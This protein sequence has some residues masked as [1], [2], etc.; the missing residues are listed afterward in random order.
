MQTSPTTSAFSAQNRPGI[1]RAFIRSITLSPNSNPLYIIPTLVCELYIETG[2]VAAHRAHVARKEFDTWYKFDYRKNSPK[3]VL[4]YGLLAAHLNYDPRSN[5]KHAEDKPINDYR[6]HEPRETWGRVTRIE[7]KEYSVTVF[8]A[9]G[10]NMQTR[11]KTAREGYNEIER[12]KRVLNTTNLYAPKPIYTAFPAGHGT[13][14]ITR[15]GVTNAH[16]V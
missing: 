9:N 12:F 11:A 15:Y 6:G 7:G 13:L 2:A 4:V 14:Y 1:T 10:F 3:H 5:K 8:C 16:K